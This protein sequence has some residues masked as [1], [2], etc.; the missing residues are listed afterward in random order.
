MVDFTL[1]YPPRRTFWNWAAG[2]GSAGESRIGFNLVAH[3]NAGLENALWIDGRIVALAQATFAYDPKLLEQPWR[4]STE[5]GV[6]E[7][8]FEPEGQR[9]ENIQAMVLGSKFVQLFGRFTGSVKV[10]G[11]RQ[12]FTAFGVVEEHHALW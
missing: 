9:A 12:N 10:D 6:L 3:F 7:A 8:L 1:G 2:N 5:D 11:V 4:V